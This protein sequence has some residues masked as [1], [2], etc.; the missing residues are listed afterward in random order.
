MNDHEESQDARRCVALVDR[1][2]DVEERVHALVQDNVDVR[3]D[4]SAGQS[5]RATSGTSFDV[6][7]SA[8]EWPL[9]DNV[10]VLPENLD[11]YDRRCDDEVVMAGRIGAIFFG[12]HQ[13]LGSEP[14]FHGAMAALQSTEPVL[15]ISASRN[16]SPDVSIVI[17]VYGQLA[18]TLNCIHSLITHKSR[19]SAEILIIDDASP[20][21][22]GEYLTQLRCVRYR[23]QKS[24]GGFIQSCNTGAEIAAGRFVVMLNN[25]TRVTGGW[26]DNLIGSFEVWPRAGLVGS[27]MHYADGSLQEAGGIVWRD[28]SAWNYGRNDDPNRP[29]YSYARQ[30]DYVSGCSIALPAPLWRELGGFDRYFRPAYCEDVD[31]AF[32]VRSC[33]REVWFQPQ[34]R[35][36]HYEGKTSGT[37]TAA[38]IKTYQVINTKKL[39][40]RWRESLTRHNRFGEAPFFERER[41]VRKRILVIDA[42]TPTPDQDAGSVQTL[43]ALQTCIASGF[44]THFVPADNWLFQ[45]KYTTALQAIGVDCAFAPYEIGFENYIRRY[46]W[47]FDAILAYRVGIVEK[48][49]PLLKSHAPHAPVMFHLAD[50]HYLRME[51]TAQVTEDAEMKYAAAL[52]K[53]RE[54]SIVNQV[55]CTISHSSFERDILT[56]ETPS[57]RVVVWPL[58]VE[59]FGTKAAFCDRR[60]LCFLGGYMHWP[61]VDAVVYFVKEI[62]PLIKAQEPGIRFVIAGAHPSEEVR[63]LSAPDIIVTGMVDDLRDLFDPCRVF[64]CPLRVGAGAKGKVASALSY[65]IPV[66]ST[67]L[68]IEGTEIAHDKHVLVADDRLA[69]AEAVLRVYRSLELW[70]RLSKA[71]Q[72]L[73]KESFS[74]ERGKTALASALEIAISHN[75]GLDVVAEQGG[76]RRI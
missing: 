44:K 41:L 58:M 22:S 18:Y 14:D 57:S 60:D 39:F 56:S 38:G 19:Y 4:L 50:L 33:G 17:P 23:R 63:V 15:Q 2:L 69:F 55:D 76:A 71:G 3:L 21:E 72:E 31:L 65:G 8:H 68:G 27:K 36:I 11:L 24:N 29:Q 49:L 46:G 45:P 9:A 53:E 61:N 47:L 42:T 54:L 6:P 26:L 5:H 66:V 37:S 59:H 7:R 32:R 75:L 25:D 20:D 10:S 12:Q 73:V 51:R 35:I 28:G 48:V 70:E 43:M 1:L 30:V 64:V 62:F 67:P 34:S 52:M 74:L 40:L 13:L 16:A